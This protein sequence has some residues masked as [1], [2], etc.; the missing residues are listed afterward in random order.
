MNT[1][2]R[3]TLAA[4]ALTLGLGMAGSASAY[5]L[6]A[7]NCP[8]NCQ[9]FGDFTVYSLALLNA[10]NTNPPDYSPT[11]NDPWAVPGS[12]GQIADFV[13]LGTQ[14][15]GQ[16]VVTNPD[17]MDNAYSTPAQNTSSTFT[18]ADSEP[19]NGPSTGDGSGSWDASVSALRDYLADTN[20][21]LVT[22]FRFNE[23]GQNN[24]DGEDMLIWA[25]ATLVD[26]DDPTNNIEFYLRSNTSGPTAP[27]DPTTATDPGGDV[28][29]NIANG[30]YDP[31]VYV[32][33]LICV[34]GAVFLHEGACTGADPQ[35][36]SSESSNLGDNVAAFAIYSALLD[37]LVRDPNSIYDILRVD[38]VMAFLNGGG[39]AAWIANN[40]TVGTTSVPEP[41]SLT[42]LGISLL[43]MALALRLRRKH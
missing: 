38:W 24:L 17:E 23:T 3:K 33:S 9:V 32:N 35:G 16:P 37:Q 34:N 1:T 27:P 28:Q 26:L 10:M 30:A 20:S 15:N 4:C 42:L 22:Y 39:E 41:V 31:Y 11:G 2:L 21:Q 6:P 40:T 29:Q 36:S 43:G 12:D 5:E 14:S 19:I 25:R 7:P 13:V 8:I 18:T